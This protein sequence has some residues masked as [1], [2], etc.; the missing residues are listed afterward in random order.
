MTT[1]T[2][3]LSYRLLGN[4]L[5]DFLYFIIT[6]LLF[7]GTG[8]A[9]HHFFWLSSRYL[10]E[11]NPAFQEL[12]KSCARAVDLLALAVGIKMGLHWLILSEKLSH[13]SA[14]ASDIV[15]STSLAYVCL[16]LINVFVAGFLMLSSPQLSSMHQMLLPS[17][18]RIA[19]AFILLLLGAHIFQLLSHQPIGSVLAGLGIGGLAV[20]MAAKETIA[21]FFG[22]LVIFADKP[23]AL[24]DCIKIDA[25]Q[26]VV[27]QVGLRSTRI[28]TLSGSLLTLAN[29]DLATKS[30]ENLSKIKFR[31]KIMTIELDSETRAA[32]VEEALSLI[33]QLLDHH[34]GYQPEH[35]P[36][37]HL[38]ELKDYKIS[39]T[40]S[41][42]YYDPSL[43]KLNTFC[44]GFYLRLLKA[45][46]AADIQLC[47]PKKTCC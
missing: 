10:K 19:Q 8:R 20:A 38:S 14:L 35:P 3:V 30:I 21:N 17:L 47:S 11:K 7:I 12:F 18:K 23:F 40:V 45:F 1:L 2:A 33:R 4:T 37:V 39:I 29:A 5:G 42:W 31:K 16:K 44:E 28:R 15:L 9:L 25:Y 26:G 13:L 34:E 36:A 46:E 43:T 32:K 27:E 22:S 6:L 24:G 41:L